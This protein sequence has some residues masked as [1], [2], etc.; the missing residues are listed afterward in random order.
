MAAA[1]AAGAAAVTSRAAGVGGVAGAAAAGVE[2]VAVAER[3][4]V[5]A[6]GCAWGVGSAWEVAAGWERVAEDGFW[7]VVGWDWVAMVAALLAAV[8]A[9]LERVAAGLERAA[10]GWERAGAGWAEAGAGSAP[11]VGGEAAAAAE[12]VVG[13]TGRLHMG[14]GGQC[15]RKSATQPTGCKSLR[16]PGPKAPDAPRFQRPAAAWPAAPPGVTQSAAEHEAFSA[17]APPNLKLQLGVVVQLTTPAV[18]SPALSRKDWTAAAG[19][20]GGPDPRGREGMDGPS[21]GVHLRRR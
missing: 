7:G 16:T 20:K 1:A 6:M 10:V 2:G 18:P 9:G 3:G 11:G 12:A 13:A 5:A 17:W 8:A 15:M 21:A 19:G 4:A 14:G